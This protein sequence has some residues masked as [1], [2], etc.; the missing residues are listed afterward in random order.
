MSVTV[1]TAVSAR[2]EAAVATAL[3][4]ERELRVVRRCPDIADLLAV[5]QAG[6]AQ[7][8]VISPDLQ[9]MRRSV[10]ADLRLSKVAIVG[11]YDPLDDAQERTLRQ[12]AVSRVVAVSDAAGLVRQVSEAAEPVDPSSAPAPGDVDSELV[13]L[14][15]DPAASEPVGHMVVS[16]GTPHLVVDPTEA[17][18]ISDIEGVDAVD[19]VEE[20][21]TV[22]RI[23]AVWGGTGS[24]GRT[25]V[26][27][28]LAAELAA[29]G[30]SAM[31]VDADTYG[32][33]VGQLL[34]LLDEAPGIAAGMRLAE[35]GRLDVAALAAVAPV[36]TPGLRVLTGISQAA[37]WPEIREEAL[38]EVLQT[39]RQLVDFV[40]VD[41]AAPI[42]EDEELS[43]DTLAPCRNA[44]TLA[45]LRAAHTLIVVGTADP[46]GLQRLV[47]A[48]EDV[49]PVVRLEPV[50]VVTR[51][52]SSAVGSS[53][54]AKVTE[55]LA[56][57]AGVSDLI[58]VPEDRE[59]VDAAMLAGR[60]LSVSFPHS[61]ARSAV[62]ALASRLSGVDMS[63][64]RSRLRSLR[65]SARSSS[66]AAARSAP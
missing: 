6:R 64:R 37:R 57:F 41:C 19:A 51:V 39:A 45:T 13:Q 36:V 23:V 65:R 25:T 55:A 54:N 9:G 2:S 43:Y 8:V 11:V 27:V 66:A 17:A 49:R 10:L 20:P 63:T 46:V 30:K 1:V 7:V 48:L 56:R 15:A 32:A 53:P 28:N 34:A 47:R 16:E 38:T 26:A 40:I 42:E 4:S 35:T 50:V 52:R 5:A 14:L 22:G 33:S 18:D 59:A 44:A 3:G 60:T 58:L 31:I 61:A 24:P 62:R 12:W 21:S 29:V